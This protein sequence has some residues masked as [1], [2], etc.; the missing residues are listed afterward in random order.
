MWH[1]I[2]DIWHMTG[3]GRGYL[4]IMPVNARD[5]A[6][7]SRDKQGQSRDKSGTNREKQGQTGTFPFCPSLSLL[8][9][10]CPCLSLLVLV[11]PCM[12]LLVP[13][14]PYMS[15][16]VSV[17]P[18]VSLSVLVCPCMSLKLLYLHV[19]PWRWIWTVFISY[20]DFPCKSHCSE[21]C[22]PC[23]LTSYLLFI[24]ILH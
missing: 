4:P 8:V 13:V 2:Y 20:I 6:G 22:K 17:C 3:G 12:S 14:C 18:C 16:S 5:K 24:L 19:Y 7:T 1:V 11:C 15:L 21:A 23:F 10:V 9:P